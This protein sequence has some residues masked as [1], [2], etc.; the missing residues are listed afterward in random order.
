[1]SRAIVQRVVRHS[2]DAM[3]TCD[4]RRVTGTVAIHATIDTTGAV[5][6]VEAGAESALADADVVS[7]VVEVFR[8]LVFPQPRAGNVVLVYP[9]R[10]R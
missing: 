8:G 4:P 5:A 9:I 3:R 1:M 10:F 7:C 6:R 2:I